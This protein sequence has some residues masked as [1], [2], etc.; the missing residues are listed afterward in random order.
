MKANL[1]VSS[2]VLKHALDKKYGL[3][4]PY[5]RVW[6]GK[7]KVV[8]I[9]YGSIFDCYARISDLKAELLRR[10]LSSTVY[11][12][13]DESNCF[14]RFFFCFK[15]SREGFIHGCRKVIGLDACHLKG[16]YKGVLL[17]ATVIDGN[18]G[19]FPL[20]YAVAEIES[21]NSWFWLL[22]NLKDAIG[23]M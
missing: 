23:D 13:L 12:E 4:L 17:G 9:I 3:L 15:A 20:A 22:Q 6:W 19:L 1:D 7:V 2:L 21:R 8:K 18:S 5:Q 14:S 16:K 10:N 11:F